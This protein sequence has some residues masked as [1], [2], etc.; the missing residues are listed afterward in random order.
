[1]YSLPPV[2]VGDKVIDHPHTIINFRFII[3]QIGHMFPT[4]IDI[5]IPLLLVNL[6]S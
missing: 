5:I 2:Y 6:V 4:L 1:M 3:N